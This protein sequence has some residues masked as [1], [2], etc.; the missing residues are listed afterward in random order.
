MIKYQDFFIDLAKI[1]GTEHV[2]DFNTVAK[3]INDMLEQVDSH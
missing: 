2:H 1:G 3:I